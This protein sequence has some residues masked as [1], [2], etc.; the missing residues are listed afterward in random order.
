MEANSSASSASFNQDN[1]LFKTPEKSRKLSTQNDSPY[2]P[3]AITTSPVQRP[4]SSIVYE[5]VEESPPPHGGDFDIQRAQILICNRRVNDLNDPP[6]IEEYS[7]SRPAIRIVKRKH[8]V[9]YDPIVQRYQKKQMMINEAAAAAAVAEV[10]AEVVA[11]AEVCA[12]LKP[13]DLNATPKKSCVRKLSDCVKKTQNVKFA[14]TVG[15]PMVSIREIPKLNNGGHCTSTEMRNFEVK[16]ERYIPSVPKTEAKSVAWKLL[17]CDAP[18]RKKPKLN[19][20]AYLAEEKRLASLGLSFRP[21]FGTVDIIEPD[22]ITELTKPTSSKPAPMIPTGAVNMSSSGSLIKQLPLPGR[23]N[24]VEP[25]LAPIPVPF[26]ATVSKTESTPQKPVICQVF[27]S[28]PD[29][30]YGYQARMA[31]PMK[32]DGASIPIARPDFSQPPPQID[33]YIAKF[34]EPSEKPQADSVSSSETSKVEL[35]EA[36]REMLAMLKSKGYVKSDDPPSQEAPVYVATFDEKDLNPQQIQAVEAAQNKAN[37]ERW[38]QCGWKI[39]EPCTYFVYRSGGC[40]RGDNCRFIHDEEMKK[41]LLRQREE[42]R[43]DDEPIRNHNVGYPLPPE[44]NFRPMSDPR[45]MMRGAFN[46]G[47]SN[48]DRGAGFRGNYRGA[49]VNRGQFDERNCFDSRQGFEPRQGFD[50]R[51]GFEHRRGFENR[52]GYEDRRGMDNR[53]GFSHR[54]N[55][56]YPPRNF[57]GRDRFRRDD[58]RFDRNGSMRPYHDDNRDEDRERNKEPREVVMATREFYFAIIGHYDQPIFEMDFPNG[59]KKFKESADTRHLN[60]YIGH[61]ALD[62]VDEHALTT[63]HMYL[64]MVDKFNEWYVSAFVTAS[65]VRFIM[66]HT[67]RVD[68]GIKQFFQEMYETYIKHAMNPFYGID[69]HI[70]SEAFEQ[71]A[72]LYGKKYLI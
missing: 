7:P 33:G 24:P 69:E 9:M 52:R 48:M 3:S 5:E 25:T 67:H 18:C 70:K 65:R 46:R 4:A 36:L 8:A 21:Q 39:P 19:T 54:R 38:T 23:K 43:R 13:I 59:E 28:S 15:L 53:R 22:D 61:A 42:S 63:T 62:I 57:R 49:N 58:D 56:P 51:R 31:T 1:F 35:P 30:G 10:A 2:T 64:K 16:H 40:I 66:L 50:N 41:R 6:K 29:V 27:E 26:A 60:H 71:K 55:Q 68:E 45:N 72:I 47:A 20:G 17:E 12:K 44:N 14:D 32:R 37:G 34:A 11:D